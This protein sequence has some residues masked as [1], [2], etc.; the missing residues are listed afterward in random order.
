MSKFK[1]SNKAI[2]TIILTGSFLSVLSMTV[3]TTAIPVIMNDLSISA[4]TAQ[5]LNSIF[6]IIIGLLAPVSAYELNRFTSRQ[7]FFAAMLSFSVGTTLGFLAYD[8]NVLLL[9]RVFQAIGAGLFLPLVSAVI[10]AVYPMKKRG[11]M[12]GL[13][14]LIGAFA[15]AVGPSFSGWL[16]EFYDWRMIF[17]VLLPIIALDMAAG[18]FVLTNVTKQQPTRLDLPSVLLSSIGLA[19]FLYGCNTAGVRDWS[20]W[21]VWGSVLAGAAAI[22]WFVCRQFLIRKPILDLRVF[23]NPIYSITSVIAMISFASMI[24]AETILPIYMQSI[25][26]LTPFQSG[27]VLLPGAVVLGIVSFFAGQLFDWKGARWLS[28]GGAVLLALFTFMLTRLTPQT[29]IGYLTFVQ[30]ARML[31]ISMINMP[32]RTAGLNELSEKYISHGIAVGS[33]TRQIGAG[34][35]TAL[36]IVVMT[37]SSQGGSFVGVKGVNTA[38]FVAT[39]TSIIA[40]IL[41]LFIPSTK[42]D[43]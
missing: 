25:M 27:L 20:D 21:E 30:T 7:I 10:F 24:S 41:S 36:L 1:N 38:F 32:V 19:A 29:T 34:I 22:I 37:L 3:M 33:S 16:L 28:I 13:S 9:G 17:L 5:W 14:G 15:P 4:N 35:G 31:G 42:K 6:V 23:Q 12:M 2:M 18:Y 8:F 39:I 43:N 26:N 11:K 40:L